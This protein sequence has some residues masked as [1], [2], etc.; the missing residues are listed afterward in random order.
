MLKK[1]I[2]VIAALSLTQGIEIYQ[3]TNPVENTLVQVEKKKHHHKKHKKHHKN[4][5]ESIPACNS[6]EFAEGKCQKDKATEKWNVP[7]AD[8]TKHGSYGYDQLNQKESIPACNSFQY[9]EGKCEKASA[10]A[11]WNV[12]TDNG[13]DG[14]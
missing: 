14:W 6:H 3:D 1:S 4:K 2:P 5:Q 9:A 11:E 10:T 13:T 7:T 12:P 8:E